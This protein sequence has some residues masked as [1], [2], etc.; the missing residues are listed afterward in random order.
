MP[1]MVV[2]YRGERAMNMIL[3]GR[4]LGAMS[5][6]G[7]LAA[8][9]AACGSGSGTDDKSAAAATSSATRQAQV[10]AAASVTAGQVYNL[11]NTNSGN[12][13]DIAGGGVADGTNVQVWTINGNAAQLWRLDANADGSYTLINPQSAKALDVAWA[14]TADGTNVAIANPNGGGA[15]KWRLNPVGNAYTLINVNSGKALDVAAA[16]TAPGANV[17]IW[18][19]NG[20]GAQ[21]WE[22]R[23][24]AAAGGWKLVWSDEFNG[25][26]IDTSKW[27]FE[28][29]AL[30]GYNNELQYYTARPENARIEDGHLVIEARKENYTSSE[31]TRGY[32]SARMRTLNKG[33]W[34]YGRMEARIKLPGGQ[35][36][37]PAFWM[38]PTD[39]K[40][41]AWAASGEI[42]IM[43]AINLN[44]NNNNVYGSIH[45]GGVSPNNTHITVGY[46][47]P[48]SAINN[49]HVYAVEWEPTQI[50]WYVDG[51]LYSTQSS[52]WSAGGA[53]P[54]PFDQRFHILLNLAVGGNWPGNPDGSTVF[55][56]QMDVD[57]VRVYQK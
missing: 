53:Y 41:G 8:L 57:Y 25:S 36:I 46:G 22:L 45:F 21:Q 38:L 12:A 17:Q 35:G 5:L 56:Q 11:I 13:L 48:D 15:Q 27:S 4:R 3:I 34:L 10:T 1:A 2:V 44:A 16:S 49:Y 33:D 31:G 50:R 29:N 26:A 23:P 54:A 19:P 51:A 24:L 40:Y 42:D 20:T 39:N 28:V 37:W 47:L 43:E 52:W 7:V 30:G 32:T 14:G 6:A 55:S 18:T 9:L